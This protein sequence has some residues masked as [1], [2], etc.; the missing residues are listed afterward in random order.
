MR[1]H[2]YLMHCA[3]GVIDT[4]CR[5]NAVS[6]TPHAQKICRTTSKSENHMQNSDGMQKK[7]KI[8]AVSLIPHSRMH[9]V[10]MTPHARCVR[11]HWYRMHRCTV[12]AVSLTPHAKYDTACTID[13]RFERP[14]QPLKEISVK[15][16]YVP[17]LSYP[18]T[19]QI[20]KFNG[21]T[22]QKIFVY[23]VPL[24]PHARFLL[25]KIDHISANSKQNSKKPVNQRPR[26]YYLMKKTEGQKSRDTVPITTVFL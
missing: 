24:T 18:T 11:C 15:N 20:Y 21:A 17:E 12:H 16:I 22:Y 5:V 3:S 8:H 2:W 7:L 9:V 25:S 1:Y 14:W 19:K 13:Q 6:S 26:G 10:S 23:A 4:A